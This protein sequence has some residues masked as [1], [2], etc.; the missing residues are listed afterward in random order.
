[1]E[2]TLNVENTILS[3]IADDA[4]PLEVTERTREIIRIMA[5]YDAI[6]A[7][8]LEWFEKHWASDDSHNDDAHKHWETFREY[9]EKWLVDSITENTS[10]IPFKGI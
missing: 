4:R 5:A 2:N 8:L 3:I 1:M 7:D 9:L 10:T 6:F